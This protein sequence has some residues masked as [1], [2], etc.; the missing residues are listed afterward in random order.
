VDGVFRPLDDK[1]ARGVIAHQHH[2]VLCGREVFGVIRGLGVELEP[3]KPR[4]LVLR[5]AENGGL[6]FAG[7]AVDGQ[8]ELAVVREAHRPGADFG[9]HAVTERSGLVL[10]AMSATA[11]GE[12]RRLVLNDPAARARL[13]RAR[14]TAFSSE[15]IDVA[16]SFGIRLSAEDVVTAMRGARRLSETRWIPDQ[17]EGDKK[18]QQGEGRPEP[19]AP[20]V[21][22]PPLPHSP[23]RSLSGWT[24]VT[25]RWHGSDPVVHWCFTEG[26]DF[27]DPFFDQTVGRCLSDPFRLFFWQE[28][29]VDELVSWAA[30]HPGLEPAGLVFHASRCG[31][32]LVAQM[33]A[34]V[35][36][37][38]VLSEP[39]PLDDLLRSQDHALEL[40]EDEVA[41]R[42]RAVVSAL[43]HPRRPAQKRLIIKLD[44]WA[45]LWLP[46]IRRAFPATPCIFL[47]R[48][49]ARVVASHMARPGSH[50]VPGCF[51]SER[52]TGRSPHPVRAAIGA[53]PPVDA[54]PLEGAP[55]PAPDPPALY[56][57]RVL[58][59]LYRAAL[60]A[61]EQGEVHLYHY[62]EL[63]EL[64]SRC[65]APLFG[66]VPGPDETRM[67][68]D[69]ALRDSRN[70]ML[71]FTSGQEG[72]KAVAPEIEAAVK[73]F[74]GPL[75]VCLEARRRA[76]LERR[77]Y[78][79]AGARP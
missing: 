41:E 32:T 55:A 35:A 59:A 73:Q 63:P 5:P 12:L 17:C 22:L 43:G 71:P 48:E 58:A 18:G 45:I 50:M 51:P 56:C 46:I 67:L 3:E 39:A 23:A 40:S 28:S 42:L 24:P 10:P 49:P 25:V 6:P 36:S 72:D 47:Y 77:P 9:F 30:A 70:P 20:D 53:R 2:R 68:A 19:R 52:V 37:T 1:A 15:V 13:F 44:A 29:S 11:V 79:G 75:Y 26:I 61:A 60:A 7:G 34:S 8:Q 14:A 38:L 76:Q 16:E 69:V 21:Q 64:V 66:V 74:A 4:Y 78:G 65:L 62:R 57:S 27:T 33:F 31:S 54:P